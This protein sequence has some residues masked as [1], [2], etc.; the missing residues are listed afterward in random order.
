MGFRPAVFGAADFDADRLASVGR[1]RDDVGSLTGDTA[2]AA[3]AAAD[4][5]PLATSPMAPP[6]FDATSPTVEAAEPAAEAAIPASFAASVATSDAASAA[7]VARLTICFRPFLAWADASCWSRFDS[8]ARAA[9]RRFSSLRNS[10]AALLVGDPPLGFAIDRSSVHRC[11]ASA[12][13]C[14]TS[15]VVIPMGRRRRASLP[16]PASELA[17]LDAFLDRS[18]RALTDP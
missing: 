16:R 4:P 17:T 15:R 7:C 2:P 12:P 5:T 14:I 3:C 9:I 18:R 6:T 8:V 10:F 1:A 13:S 11:A